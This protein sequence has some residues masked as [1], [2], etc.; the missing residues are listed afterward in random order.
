MKQFLADFEEVWREMPYKRLFFTLFVVWFFAFHYLGNSTFG[1]V[2]TPSLFA[3]MDYDYHSSTDDEHGYLIPFVVLGLLW[4]K[5]KELLAVRKDLWWP[6]LTIIVSALLLHIFG[7]AIQQTRLS[8]VAYFV[9]LYGIT[10]LVWGPN[11]LRA[12]FFPF[13]LF[14]F[15]VPLS[16]VSETVTFPLRVLVT[17]I[18]VGLARNVLGIAVI[19]DGVRIADPDGTFSYEVAAACSGIRSL[20]ALLA[21]TTIYGFT[22]FRSVW[23]QIFMMA[24]AFPLAVIGNVARLTGIIVTA[25]AFGQKA[26]MKFHDY[27]GFVTFLVAII[28][29]MLLGFLLKENEEMRNGAG[30]SEHLRKRESDGMGEWPSESGGMQKPA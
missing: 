4:W 9:G 27:A 10:G 12:T 16:T 15:C 23:K 11:W 28:C 20:T 14:A 2:D 13:F 24:I 1:Y 7:Y 21:L 8:I 30:D 25:E 3:W 22:T 29:I 18:S 17:K 26:G 19:Q 6:A 5:R